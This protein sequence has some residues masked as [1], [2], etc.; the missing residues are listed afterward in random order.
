MT[1]LRAVSLVLTVVVLVPVGSVAGISSGVR[2]RLSVAV[3]RCAK[4]AKGKF[5]VAKRGMGDRRFAEAVI[6]LVDYDD[7][8]AVGLII[9]RRSKVTLSAALPQIDSLRDRK[10]ELF[11]GGPVSP[12]QLMLLIRSSEAPEGAVEVFDSIYFSPGP[13]LLEHVLRDRH[14]RFRAYA[15]YAG[16]GPGQLDVELDRGDW[17]VADADAHSI[18]SDMPSS[19]WPA[20]IARF[21]GQW[22]MMPANQA[23][24]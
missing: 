11:L 1:I 19:I 15:G 17:F 3:S 12:Q 10:D 6:L 21:E 18:F 20:L 5:L 22:A 2:P 8:G 7:N 23:G 14:Q 9:N 24:C 13:S 4:P 16:W